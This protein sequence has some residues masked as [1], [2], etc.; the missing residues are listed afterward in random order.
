[1]NRREALRSLSL[2]MGYVVAVPAVM[3]MLESC[4]EDAETW[5]AVFL[6]DEEKHLVTHLVD[7]ILP[8]SAIPGGLDLNLPQFIDMMCKDV[9]KA[10]DQEM[11]HQGSQVFSER[12]S[13]R[14]N[15]DMIK[16]KKDEVL[17]LFAEYFDKSA[18]ESGIILQEQRNSL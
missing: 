3:N 13:E 1:M 17:A 15:K 6:T 14:F 12:F 16:A 2:S 8:S 9:M 5:T 4:T 11:F 7:I 10:S 18:D